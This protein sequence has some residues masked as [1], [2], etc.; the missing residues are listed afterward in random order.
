[1]FVILDVILLAGLITLGTI[2][3]KV[4]KH[5]CIC[6]YWASRDVTWVLLN[7]KQGVTLKQA[8]I[9]LVKMYFKTIYKTHRTRIMGA[10]RTS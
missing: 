9:P 7:L 6:V 8:F 2:L 3:Y 5:F 4:F 10:E 1:M